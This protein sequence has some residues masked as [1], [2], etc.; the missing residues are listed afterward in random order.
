MKIKREVII[1]YIDDYDKKEGIREIY[2]GRKGDGNK[3]MRR[4]MSMTVM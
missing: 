1:L 4:G 3:E 2:D